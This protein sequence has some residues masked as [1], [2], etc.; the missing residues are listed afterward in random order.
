MPSGGRLGQNA[1]LR[2]TSYQ[3]LTVASYF[4]S[5]SLSLLICNMGIKN[6]STLTRCCGDKKAQ[7]LVSPQESLAIVNSKMLWPKPISFCF[8]TCSYFS[9]FYASDPAIFFPCQ[10]SLLLSSPS[11]SRLNAS[12]ARKPNL[13]SPDGSL[14]P[15]Q[16]CISCCLGSEEPGSGAG[17][18]VWESC[19][20]LPSH[21]VLAS[22][23]I[24][25]I[26]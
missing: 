24:C 17:Q 25:V 14:P 6:S 7:P 21:L 4:I 11:Q 18:P 5:H 22:F 20:P 8:Q 9:C 15:P 13:G 16:N 12:F 1:L 26:K 10:N 3:W 2:T 23:H 19:P